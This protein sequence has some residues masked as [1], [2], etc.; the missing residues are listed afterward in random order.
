MRRH[1]EDFFY[2]QQTNNM[3]VCLRLHNLQI[4]AQKLIQSC[5]R[6]SPSSMHALE[7]S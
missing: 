3:D 5:M 6:A 2:F 7:Y 1:P 4:S